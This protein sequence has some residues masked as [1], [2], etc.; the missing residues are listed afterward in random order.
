MG[1][2]TYTF[3]GDRATRQEL[4]GMQCNPIRDERGKCI[5][6]VKFATAAVI[7]EDGKFYVVPRRRLR[8]NDKMTQARQ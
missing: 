5:L 8:R 7:G 4:R 3:L 6:S 1:T 2:F